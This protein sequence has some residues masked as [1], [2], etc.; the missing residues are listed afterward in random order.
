MRL[1]H[2]QPQRTWLHTNNFPGRLVCE[3]QLPPPPRDMPPPTYT[4]VDW[5]AVPPDTRA[6]M[7]LA[8]RKSCGFGADMHYDP[9]R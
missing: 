2:G 6:A 4:W 9:A 5:V 8:T 3:A 7:A 1:D